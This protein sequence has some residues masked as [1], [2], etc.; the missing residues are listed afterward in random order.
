[1]R[2]SSHPILFITL[3][4]PNQDH[5][6]SE[7]ERTVHGWEPTEEGCWAAEEAAAAAKRVAAPAREDPGRGGQR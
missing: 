6:L 4:S 3:P 7:E 2:G 1:M 5:T